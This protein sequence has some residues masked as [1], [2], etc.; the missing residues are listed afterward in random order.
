MNMLNVEVARELQRDRE[1]LI[2]ES[3]RAQPRAPRNQ[4]KRSVMRGV[5]TAV[6]A[7]IRNARRW[8]APNP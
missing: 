3:R 4:A 8:L 7:I 2:A 5:V 1:R 6:L